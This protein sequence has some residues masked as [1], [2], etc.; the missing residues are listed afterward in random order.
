MKETN[1]SVLFMRQIKGNNSPVVIFCLE[2]RIF[3]LNFPIK[4]C[5]FV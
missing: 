3:V 4:L 5:F 2:I 1:I